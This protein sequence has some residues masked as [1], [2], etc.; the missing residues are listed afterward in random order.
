MVKESKE[1]A[2]NITRRDHQ[3]R[4]NGRKDLLSR[5]LDSRAAGV[6][7]SVGPEDLPQIAVITIGAVVGG[8]TL[9]RSMRRVPLGYE[10]PRVTLGRIGKKEKPGLHLT[11]PTK[12]VQV[13]PLVDMRPVSIDVPGAARG[14]L[15]DGTEIDGDVV[16]TI[17]PADSG[18]VIERVAMAPE[19]T[20]HLTPE[21]EH[22]HPAAAG[23]VRKFLEDT[24]GR[25]ADA[26][27]T[28]ATTGVP[29]VSA[30]TR[31]GDVQALRHSLITTIQTHLDDA[32]LSEN[33]KDYVEQ[34][35][36]KG[37]PRN[38]IKRGFW[39]KNAEFS[40]LRVSDEVVG[41]MQEEVGARPR[42]RAE[43]MARR[44]LGEHYGDFR[45]ATAAEQIAAQGGTIVVNLGRTDSGVDPASR[46]L[47]GQSKKKNRPPS[48]TASRL[49]Q[50][51][52]RLG[53]NGK[54]GRSP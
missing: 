19:V 26:A 18:T 48:S 45:N 3:D 23:R 32:I 40:N 31:H 36:R 52:R 13:M 2:G 33:D 10:S 22:A 51:A 42:L 5:A 37:K 15:G 39:V 28:E 6:I 12:K 53:G 43:R 54:N 34:E 35:Q 14:F 17:Q 11:D 20:L 44:A 27:G 50:T 25:I 9:L 24:V 7:F 30:L 21:Y 16:V 47:L 49:V 38:R 1:T 4:R 8:L 41:A 46:A 29:E